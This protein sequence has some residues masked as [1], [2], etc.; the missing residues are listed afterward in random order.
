MRGAGRYSGGKDIQRCHPVHSTAPGSLGARVSSLT[1]G[2]KPPKLAVHQS[3]RTCSPLA[4]GPRSYTTFWSNPAI[5]ALGTGGGEVG[6]DLV[7]IELARA[8][9]GIQLL[10]FEVGVLGRES[11]PDPGTNKPAEL[12]GLTRLKRRPLLCGLSGELGALPAR[13]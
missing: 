5:H 9:P 11:G 12:I 2:N 1:L 6:M 4:R 8:R 10:L 13:S 7:S 3:L